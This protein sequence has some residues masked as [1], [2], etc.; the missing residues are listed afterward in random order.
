MPVTG[1]HPSKRIL[2]RKHRP[3]LGGFVP[4]IDGAGKKAVKHAVIAINPVLEGQHI[5]FTAAS[6]LFGTTIGS[7]VSSVGYFWGI[8]AA[9][10]GLFYIV[11]N[12]HTQSGSV[13][14]TFATFTVVMLE[15]I[16]GLGQVQIK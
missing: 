12:Q 13:A 1:G 11:A 2:Q 14:T 4:G 7:G 5:A 9:S 15:G 6:S 16:I 10:G 3:I 8:T